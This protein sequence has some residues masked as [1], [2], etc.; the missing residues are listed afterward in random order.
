MTQVNDSAY[1]Q[2]RSNIKLNTGE[3]FTT[4]AENLFDTFLDELPDEVR[5][6][7]NCNACKQFFN[8]YGSLV[9]IDGKGNVKSALLPDS[10]PDY[11]AKPLAAMLAKIRKSTVTGVFLSNEKTLGQ[12]VTGVWTH[13][14]AVMPA[15]A[16]VNNR[17]NTANQLMAQKNEDFAT[18]NRSL[19][20]FTVETI[21]TAITILKTN[22]LYR[23][24]RFLELAEWFLDVKKQMPNRLS[25]KQRNHLIWRA[26]YSAPVGWANVRGSMIGT[27]L[28]DIQNGLSFDSVK[29]RFE[30]KM[31]T[32][33][34]S[35]AAPTQGAINQAERTFATLGYVRSDL[36]RRYLRFDEIQEFIWRPS[37]GKTQKSNGVFGSVAPKKVVQTTPN[38]TLPTQPITW[39]KF[40]RDVLPSASKVEAKVQD[41]SR[42]VAMVTTL[43]PESKNIL[44][45]NN[46]VSW[47]Y[48]G[49][50][51]DATIKQRVEFAGGQYEG[52]DIRAS[53]LWNTRSDLDLHAKAPHDSHI[54]FG[55]I[56]GNYGYLDVD[57]NVS[58]ETLEPVENIR[59]QHAPNG[60]YEIWVNNYRDRNHQYNPYKV[61]LE[62]NG[63]I[64][65]FEG[66]LT[67]TGNEQSIV[68]FSYSR[69]SQP[70]IIGA[71]NVAIGQA[72]NLDLAQYHEV[73]GIVKTPNQ[74]GNAKVNSGDAQI[75]MLLEG[76]K[77][78][79][80]GSGRGFLTEMLVSELQPI[81]ST[82]NAFVA[83]QQIE[84]IED[85]TANGIGLSANGTINIDLR[86][87]TGNTVANY[88]IDRW[89]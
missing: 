44:R 65:N 68:R 29:I 7:Y 79:S 18:L 40:L 2:F 19:E 70:S 42:F 46:P 86:V 28:D 71:K 4:D 5:Q 41:S 11:F 55:K 47:Y 83:N 58:G 69:G 8:R 73:T 43:N 12:P 10:A 76:A 38:L 63:K 24:Q 13:F 59:W 50:G 31:G 16:V 51:Y 35:Q 1:E 75:I 85:A 33:Q 53:L 67:D 25:K 89:D 22:V 82:L 66:T 23:S 14:H 3:L 77:D 88:K 48:N 21:E 27:L 61:E 62:V 64:Y 26:V 74:W 80:S 52:N 49:G 15:N 32:Y 39:Q 87:T 84:G 36:E 72:W 37:I 17:T 78:V 56:R 45:W 60:I 34:V 57:M 9:T 81:R 30:E 54:Y 6:H 20:A